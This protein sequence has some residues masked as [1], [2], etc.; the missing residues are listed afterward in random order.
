MQ[1]TKHALTHPKVTC[2]FN[3][4]PISFEMKLW[5]SSQVESSTMIPFPYSQYM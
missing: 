3:D 1:N 4:I 2:R 5:T